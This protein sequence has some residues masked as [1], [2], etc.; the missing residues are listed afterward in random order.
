MASGP[1]E[2]GTGG[3]GSTAAGPGLGAA[4]AS[5]HGTGGGGGAVG[6]IQI[7]MPPGVVPSLGANV[8]ISPAPSGATLQTH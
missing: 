3:A 1:G 2:G 7:D 6:R 5:I 8:R 4:T